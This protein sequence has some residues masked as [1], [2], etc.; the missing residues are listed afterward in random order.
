MGLWD[1]L[2]KVSNFRE[3]LDNSPLE[4]EICTIAE[5]ALARCGG[6]DPLGWGSGRA[7]EPVCEGGDSFGPPGAEVWSFPSPSLGGELCSQSR[8]CVADGQ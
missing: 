8:R 4:R 3:V 5:Q 6:G 2:E 1:E 7:W